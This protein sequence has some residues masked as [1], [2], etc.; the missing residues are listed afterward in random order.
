MS[1]S[2]QE[3]KAKALAKARDESQKQ[4]TNW[5]TTLAQEWQRFWESHWP[6]PV[7]RPNDES[8]QYTETRRAFYAG[9]TAIILKCI[10]IGE[11]DISEDEGVAYFD[12]ITR[13]AKE[14][15]Q[16]MQRILDSI[17]EDDK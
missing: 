2:W 5:K 15:A 13:E 17:H 9:A 16:K 14:F 10:R 8:V 4:W 1:K 7:E 6:D 11:P 3:R 12:A